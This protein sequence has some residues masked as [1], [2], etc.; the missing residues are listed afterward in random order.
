MS[1]ETNK[2]GVLKIC[3]ITSEIK[4]FLILQY[5]WASTKTQGK[6]LSKLSIGL[7]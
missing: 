7:G 1:R 4:D 3:N 5:F 2:R 6:V